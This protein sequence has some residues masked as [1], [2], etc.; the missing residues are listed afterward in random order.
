[1]RRRKL[2]RRTIECTPPE[3]AARQA[4]ALLREG[5]QYDERPLVLQLLDRALGSEN[6][7]EAASM[8]KY[9]AAVLAGR[10]VKFQVSTIGDDDDEEQATS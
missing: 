1:M 3:E 2:R 10:R 9:R 5:H 8:Q 7:G 6:P 4:R